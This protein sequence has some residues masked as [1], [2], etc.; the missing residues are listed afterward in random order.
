M[1]AAYTRYGVGDAAQI[2]TPGQVVLT[3]GNA[4]V[5]RAIQFGQRLRFPARYCHWNHAAIVVSQ[6]GAIVE[7]LAAGASQNN[8]SKY[9]ADEYHLVDTGLD[10]D[11]SFATYALERHAHYGYLTIASIAASLITG[12][13][14]KFGTSGTMICS[15]LVAACLGVDLWRADPSHVMPA[16]LAMMF[17]VV[18]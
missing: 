12:A 4:M 14:I 7:M 10:V 13:G 5:C 8:I 11:V 17:D 18:A 16:E 9:R 3:H 1:T 6:D 2:F 15:G